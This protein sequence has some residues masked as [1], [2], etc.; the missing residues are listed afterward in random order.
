MPLSTHHH[1]LRTYKY[2]CGLTSLLLGVRTLHYNMIL[3][4]NIVEIKRIS[5]AAHTRQFNGILIGLC[6][7]LVEAPKRHEQHNICIN[8]H[9]SGTCVIANTCKTVCKYSV[10]Y[11]MRA[12]PMMWRQRRPKANSNAMALHRQAPHSRTPPGLHFASQKFCAL[13]HRTTEPL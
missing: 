6:F 12:R 5:T 4:M 1:L 2:T 7:S 3:I 9:P 13:L 8:W 10:I 11:L